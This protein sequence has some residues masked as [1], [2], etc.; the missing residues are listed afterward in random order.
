VRLAVVNCGLILACGTLLGLGIAI[1]AV[2]GPLFE[3][4]WPLLVLVCLVTWIRVVPRNP[5]FDRV[6]RV[7][8]SLIGSS[9][10][11]LIALSG[12]AFMMVFLLD[13]DMPGLLA[14]FASTMVLGAWVA[15]SMLTYFIASR[16]RSRAAGSEES[17][18][19]I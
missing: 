3:V 9:P 19:R 14:F 11:L 13:T 2:H 4:I 17:A 7:K 12:Y 15:G 1:P 6:S 5:S 8:L 16:G 18:A 10:L